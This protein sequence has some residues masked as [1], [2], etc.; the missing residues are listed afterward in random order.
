ML[1]LKVC[2]RE[3]CGCV[4]ACVCLSVRECGVDDESEGVCERGVWVCGC[5]C[6]SVCKGVWG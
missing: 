4:G 6:L 1:I 2:V 5:V 3:G